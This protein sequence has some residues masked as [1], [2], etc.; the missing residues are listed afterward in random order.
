MQ[1]VEW[2]HVRPDFPKGAPSNSTRS[3]CKWR[4]WFCLNTPNNNNK[5]HS[6]EIKKSFPFGSAK[7]KEDGKHAGTYI[8]LFYSVDHLKDFLLQV[9][10]TQWLLFMPKWFT[11]FIHTRTHI[12]DAVSVC[13]SKRSI[14]GNFLPEDTS[15]QGIRDRPTNLA[16]SIQPTPPPEPQPSLKFWERRLNN[17]IST[18]IVIIY[19]VILLLFLLP[20]DGCPSLSLI[21]PELSSC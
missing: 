19:F 18:W 21:L 20:S 1:S 7:K 8:A 6:V 17:V 5:S 13:W 2:Y 4:A 10:F 9:S 12:G 14:K 15:A 3:L 11:T 16:N